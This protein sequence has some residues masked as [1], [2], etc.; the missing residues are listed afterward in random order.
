MP[1]GIVPDESL[2]DELLAIVH[3]AS[4]ALFPWQLLLFVNDYTPVASTTLADLVEPTF[5]GYSRRT[6]DPAAWTAPVM[7][8]VYAESTNGT[9]PQLWTN[10]SGAAVTVFGSAYLDPVT[11]RLRRVQRYDPADIV[12]VEPGGVIGVVPKFSYR[13]QLASE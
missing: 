13:S 5:S 6:L 4:T 1:N 9:D 8:G 10:G 12:A 3:E 11:G 7:V 2:G